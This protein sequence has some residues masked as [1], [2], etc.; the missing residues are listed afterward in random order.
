MRTKYFRISIT[1][2]CNLNC[3]FCHQ[4][5]QSYSLPVPYLSSDDFIWVADV[6]IQLGF[7]KFKITG[8]EPTLRED[9][10]QIISGIKMKGAED[11]S[12]ITNGIRLSKI[13]NDLYDSG[14]D[15]INVSIYSFES[16]TFKINCNGKSEDIDNIVK[17]IDTA[18]K[19]GFTDI[20]LNFILNNV[21][22]IDEF[23]NVLGFARQRNLKVLLLP[24]LKY[25]LKADDKMYSFNELYE[26][27]K[28]FGIKK[29]EIITDNEGFRQRFILTHSGFKILL[30]HDY[31]SDRSIFN[32]CFSCHK[33]EKCLEG[34]APL[35]LSSK[36]KILPCLAKG[37]S[38]IDARTIILNRDKIKFTNIIN[39][40]SEL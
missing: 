34:I 33:R 19:A 14:L 29:E 28:K 3:Y 37:I 2:N 4:E 30:R 10:T 12:L 32:S 9:L 22:R 26:F 31:L 38:E 24:M 8:G 17:G 20:K 1:D 35:R 21:N 7:Q 23:K 15:R 5:G 39:K 13:S 40:I 27:I 25:N 18:I 6:A 11:I 16:G 36:G